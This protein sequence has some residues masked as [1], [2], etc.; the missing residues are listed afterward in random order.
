MVSRAWTSRGPRTHRVRS[1]VSDEFAVLD[2]VSVHR[3]VSVGP[4]RPLLGGDAAGVGHDTPVSDQVSENGT[5]H[6]GISVP[7]PGRLATGKIIK[8]RPSEVLRDEEVKSINRTIAAGV[9][10]TCPKRARS[11]VTHGYPRSLL[12]CRVTKVAQSTT[13]LDVF[14]G[15]Q[16]TST[17]V[18]LRPPAVTSRLR[19]LTVASPQP[20]EGPPSRLPGRLGEFAQVARLTR[21]AQNAT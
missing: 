12:S 5:E 2:H 4:P 8:R 11:S 3:P 6:S 17:L 21:R 14:Q 9:P 13:R 16:A 15:D 18:A 19:S 7:G 20:V 1:V 10:R